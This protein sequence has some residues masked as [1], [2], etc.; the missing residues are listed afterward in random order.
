MLGRQASSWGPRVLTNVG[1]LERRPVENHTRVFQAV[2]PCQSLHGH[3][4]VKGFATNNLNYW[5]IYGPRHT[6]APPFIL[7]PVCSWFDKLTMS[8]DVQAPQ[9][10]RPELVL[11]AAEGLVEG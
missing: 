8:G 6:L 1:H 3:N 10:A 4:Y 11:S 5:D 2:Q 9:T 7:R